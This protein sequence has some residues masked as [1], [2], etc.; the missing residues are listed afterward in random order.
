VFGIPCSPSLADLPE[1]VDLAVLLVGDP[2]PV[3]ALLVVSRGAQR[4]C[5]SRSLE[6]LLA[7]CSRWR[8]WDLH[9]STW[10]T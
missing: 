8:L 2:L 7:P 10:L 9:W 4:L 5:I 1:Q 6:A 3:I